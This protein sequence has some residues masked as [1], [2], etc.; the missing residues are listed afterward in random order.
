MNFSC[1]VDRGMVGRSE[2][3]YLRKVFKGVCQVRHVF[4]GARFLLMVLDLRPAPRMDLSTY[5]MLIRVKFIDVSRATMEHRQRL[6][7][8]RID[9]CLSFVLSTRLPVYQNIQLM[10][11]LKSRPLKDNQ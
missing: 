5:G 9:S 3:L 10:K 1:T 8:G 7:G 11:T 2:Q 6:V 4:F